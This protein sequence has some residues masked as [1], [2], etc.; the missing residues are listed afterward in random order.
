MQVRRVRRVSMIE[1]SAGLDGRVPS[2]RSP[3]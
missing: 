2:V 3:R 1:A